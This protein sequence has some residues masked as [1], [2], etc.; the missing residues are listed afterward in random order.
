MGTP[1]RVVVL[2]VDSYT[3]RIESL[4]LPNPGPNQVVV[5]QFASGICHSQ[6]HQ[7]HGKRK[8]PVILGH[9]STGVVLETGS[10]VTHV[11][12]GDT[13]MVT[14]VPRQA[15]AASIPP[16]A[17]TLQVSDGVA[18]SQNVFTCADH[19]IADQ[20]YVVRVDPN[21]KTDVTAIIGCAVMTGAG[22]VINTADVTQ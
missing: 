19:T 20:Q 6:L 2:P 5:K 9:E 12:P 18:A 4:E 10:D 17:A 1:A 8:T 15:T 7:T 14:W 22:A 13:V 3:L 21:I 16:I 11:A